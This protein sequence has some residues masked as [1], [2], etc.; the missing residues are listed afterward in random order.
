MEIY[1]KLKPGG[2][3]AHEG[4]DLLCSSQYT[5]QFG[6]EVHE[7]MSRSGGQFEA[8]PPVFKSPSKL[9]TS[10]LTHCSRDERLGPPCP[11]RE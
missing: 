11:A 1:Y 9:G 2:T 4:Q 5:S 6:A 10:L 3:T 8:R 7:L